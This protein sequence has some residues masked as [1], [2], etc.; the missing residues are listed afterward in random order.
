LHVTAHLVPVAQ[1]ASQ[2][3]VDRRS[4]LVDGPGTGRGEAFGERGQADRPASTVP[5]HEVR[6]IMTMT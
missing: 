3:G 4:R 5:D 6:R 1:D 2:G